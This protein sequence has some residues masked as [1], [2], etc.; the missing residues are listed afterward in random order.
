MPDEVVFFMLAKLF[1]KIIHVDFVN[2]ETNMLFAR[3][4]VPMQQL[5]KSFA[6]ATVM[7]IGEED[8]SVIS[9]APMT[10]EEIKKT[11]YLRLLLRKVH[12]ANSND[13]L[14][15]IPTLSNE[16]VNPTNIEYME[17]KKI[18]K[19]LVMYINPDDWKQVELIPKSKITLLN[20]EIEKINE[21]YKEKITSGFKNVYLRLPF[22]DPIIDLHL[23]I[24][25]IEQNFKIKSKKYIAFPEPNKII[26]NG[27]YW[28]LQENSGLYGIFNN[29]NEVQFVGIKNNYGNDHEPNS[30]IINFCNNYDLLVI[31]WVRMSMFK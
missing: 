5:P 1:Q 20:S 17:E 3:S 14:Y 19:D 29:N 12:Y 22:P 2:A 10:I 8:W 15:S 30:D 21:V 31:D 23:T 26:S 4:K 27:F 6:P 7:H 9:A 25:I 16:A 11:K 28:E 13:I 24:D 18:E